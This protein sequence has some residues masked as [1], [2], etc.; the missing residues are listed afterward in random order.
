MRTWGS[1]PPQ[2]KAVGKKFV[3]TLNEVI[4]ELKH[5]AIPV[6]VEADKKKL[7]YD[8][9]IEDATGQ[10][11]VRTSSAKVGVNYKVSQN[12]TVGVE[13]K[14]GLHDAQDAAAWGKSVDDENAAQAK[15]KLLF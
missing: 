11:K 14:R 2:E 4:A 10:G 9:G 3:F 7:G 12:S 5:P 15:Y 13:L 1:K 6:A 8:F